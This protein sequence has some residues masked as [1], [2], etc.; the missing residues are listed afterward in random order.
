VNT[1]LLVKAEH[2]V[3]WFYEHISN[4]YVYKPLV[5]VRER[6]D[7][8]TSAIYSLS[9]IKEHVVASGATQE[10]YGSLP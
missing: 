1:S 10:N 9:D 2:A 6:R 8:M 7:G 5:D 3:L 4:C